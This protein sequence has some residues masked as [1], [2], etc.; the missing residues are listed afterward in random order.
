L[1]RLRVRGRGGPQS[2]FLQQRLQSMRATLLSRCAMASIV[3]L[4]VSTQEQLIRWCFWNEDKVWRYRGER[5]ENTVQDFL[6]FVH[7][8]ALPA[9][10]GLCIT[11]LESPVTATPALDVDVVQEQL[12]SL[13]ACEERVV[14]Y[15]VGEFTDPRTYEIVTAWTDSNMGSL[16]LAVVMYSRAMEEL[17]FHYH[18]RTLVM[19]IRKGSYDQIVS[20]YPVFQWLVRMGWDRYI[21]RVRKDSYEQRLQGGR[22]EY[23][24]RLELELPPL[25][26]AIRFMNWMQRVRGLVCGAYSMYLPVTSTPLL[27]RAPRSYAVVSPPP[28]DEPSF[29]HLLLAGCFRRFVFAASLGIPLYYAITSWR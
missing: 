5:T 26:H 9:Y 11:M 12:P 10:P 6:S 8:S 13:A 20:S 21:V 24:E 2:V 19:D 15:L 4:G 23:F 27:H 25:A 28:L 22:Y 7:P 1:C 18:C 17:Y 3:T 16:G 29:S 14:A